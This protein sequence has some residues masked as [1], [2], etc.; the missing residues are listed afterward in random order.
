MGEYSNGEVVEGKWIFPNGTYF[1]GKFEKNKPKGEGHWHFA[2]GNVVKGEFTQQPNTADDQVENSNS[3][4]LSW[5]T[6]T[7]LVDPTRFKEEY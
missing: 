3:V 1:Q 4:L 2:N 6:N 5:T 7:E